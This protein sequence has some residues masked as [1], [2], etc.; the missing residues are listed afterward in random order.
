ML[1]GCFPSTRESDPFLGVQRLGS[2]HSLAAS[3]GGSRCRG[4]GGASCP[5]TNARARNINKYNILRKYFRKYFLIYLKRV[6]AA[7]RLAIAITF[8]PLF[9]MLDSEFRAPVGW[10]EVGGKY[11]T[12]VISLAADWVMIGERARP[13][14]LPARAI[15]SIPIISH[16]LTTPQLRML[17]DTLYLKGLSSSGQ[18]LI[19]TR[20]QIKY[21]KHCIV[22]YVLSVQY[23]TWQQTLT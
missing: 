13:T 12:K 8:S 5:R 10:G 9:N 14:L 3:A 17:K 19:D 4:G 6:W 2:G 18:K 20:Q 1:I 11:I 7:S 22:L 16:L 15:R 21:T 23:I